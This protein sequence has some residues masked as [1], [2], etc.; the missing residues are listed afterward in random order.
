MTRIMWTTLIIGLALL[1][2]SKLFAIQISESFAE[3]N[4]IGGTLFTVIGLFLMVIDSI[5]K[6]LRKPNDLTEE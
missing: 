1:I 2:F 4:L 6:V 3:W 5:K